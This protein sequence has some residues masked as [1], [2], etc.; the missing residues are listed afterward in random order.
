MSVS[1]LLD[2]TLIKHGDVYFLSELSIDHVQKLINASQPVP[3]FIYEMNNKYE[4]R[5]LFY[6]DPDWIRTMDPEE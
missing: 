3:A 5:V 2:R 1:K 4:T 6:D